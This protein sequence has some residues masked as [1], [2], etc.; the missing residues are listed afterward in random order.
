MLCP[1]VAIRTFAV[2]IPVL[3]RGSRVGFFFFLFFLQGAAD[4]D[5]QGSHAVSV[6]YRV[7]LRGLVK[8]LC[9][10]WIPRAVEI[11]VQSQPPTMSKKRKKEK[12]ATPPP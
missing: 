5:E 1:S 8:R 3:A 7:E 12:S 2:A 4:Q 9:P 11:Q 10:A 6:C